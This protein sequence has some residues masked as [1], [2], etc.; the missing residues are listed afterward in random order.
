[1]SL[2]M[3]KCPWSSCSG[4]LDFHVGVQLSYRSCVGFSN[5]WCDAHMVQF[6][7]VSMH[8]LVFTGQMIKLVLALQLWCCFFISLSPCETWWLLHLTC[9]VGQLIYHSCVF[10][11]RNKI[12][13][14]ILLYTFQLWPWWQE[15]TV[16][17]ML[18]TCCRLPFSLQ[19]YIRMV[20]F[21]SCRLRCAGPSCWH[22]N[23]LS[24]LQYSKTSDQIHK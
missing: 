9:T 6:T 12:K 21:L 15:S 23:W 19:C 20:T 14:A 5:M 22:S 7:D 16:L 11:K 24:L 10:I 2:S 13:Y 3:Y 8:Y 1:M 17:D 4:V 18:V